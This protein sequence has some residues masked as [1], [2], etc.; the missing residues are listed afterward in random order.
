MSEAKT[1]QGSCHCGAIKFD[2]TTDLSRVITCNCSICARTGALLSFVNES[3]FKRTSGTDDDL[4]DYQFNKHN[5]HH[6]FCKKCGVRSYAHGIRPDGKP[7]IA[8]NVR[9]LPDVDLE[10]LTL[11]KFDGKNMM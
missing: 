5:I 8:I 7:M 2:V 11:T 1:Y 3:A 10:A 6:L 9:C 4:T